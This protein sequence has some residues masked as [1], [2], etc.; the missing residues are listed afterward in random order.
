M[1]GSSALFLSGRH[2]N[3]CIINAR[4][5][6]ANELSTIYPNALRSILRALPNPAECFTILA[7]GWNFALS[8][9][10]RPRADG[11]G[12]SPG[13]DNHAALFH[14]LCGSWVEFYQCE[15]TR[16]EVRDGLTT[17]PARLD[18]AYSTLPSALVADLTIM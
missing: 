1:V 9:D 17:H 18:R 2:G 5:P 15:D 4:M 11:S 16:R 7:G 13:D 10:R 3:M 12:W 6:N 14:R 8:S